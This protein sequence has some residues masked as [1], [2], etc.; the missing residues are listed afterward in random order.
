MSEPKK[1]RTA[2]Q[3]AN[4]LLEVL[5]S[6]QLDPATPEYQAIRG[7][8]ERLDKI[9]MDWA[10]MYQEADIAKKDRIKDYVCTAV[11]AVV[12]LACTGGAVFAT[13]VA[14]GLDED[15]VASKSALGVADK[16]TKNLL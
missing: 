9:C 11:N 13:L 1:I 14:C 4:F 16:F 15:K 2:R 6:K 12:K 5:D 10:R 8:Y 3:E 7:E